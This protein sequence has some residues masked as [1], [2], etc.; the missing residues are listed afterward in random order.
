MEA[1]R[2]VRDVDDRSG[3]ALCVAALAWAEAEMHQ[4]ERAARLLG[5]TEAVWRSVPAD[6]PAP[7]A[8]LRERYTAAV[9]GALGEARWSAR[10]G[11]AGPWTGHRRSPSPSASDPPPARLPSPGSRTYRSRPGNV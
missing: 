5:A 11:R 4:E 6:P 8:A 1:L 10:E 7:V 3:I 9:R 2:L